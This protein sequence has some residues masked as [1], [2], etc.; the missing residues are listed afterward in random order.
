MYENAIIIVCAHLFA[1]PKDRTVGPAH[2]PAARPNNSVVIS[3]DRRVGSRGVIHPRDEAPAI[4]D[5]GSASNRGVTHQELAP[6]HQLHG[7][8]S[9]ALTPMLSGKRVT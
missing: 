2:C 6:H 1:K 4:T 7:M 5:A 3:L 9:C 8:V